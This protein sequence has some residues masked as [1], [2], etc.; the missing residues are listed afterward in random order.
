MQFEPKQIN[1]IVNYCSMKY[2]DL[3]LSETFAK[4][5]NNYLI[6]I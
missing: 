5:L 2:Q 4:I 6:N 1:N 3:S